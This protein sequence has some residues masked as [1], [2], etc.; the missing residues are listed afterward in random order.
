[1]ERTVTTPIYHADLEK[2]RSMKEQKNLR[3]LSD[4]VRICIEYAQSHGVF[5]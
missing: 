1:M 4:A 2:L 3:K 5:T